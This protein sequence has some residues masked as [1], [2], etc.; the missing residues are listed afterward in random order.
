MRGAVRGL[1]VLIYYTTFD[2][3]VG[4]D[5][6]GVDGNGTSRPCSTE[7]L[8]QQGAEARVYRSNFFGKPTIIKE[9]FVKTY[10]V[11]TLDQ[12]LTNRRMTQ[13]VRSMARCRKN[14][15][16]TPAVYHMDFKRRSI[17]MEDIH[18]GISLKEYIKSLDRSI[19]SE[20]KVLRSLVENI[21]KILAKMHDCDI[22]HGDLTTSNMIY[23]PDKGHIT[24][25]D[26]GLSTVSGLVEDKGV[27]LYVLERAFLSTHPNTEDLF[28]ALLDSYFSS[29]GNAK[30]VIGK[31]DE[32]RLRGRKRTMVG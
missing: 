22:I 27:D 3:A 10:R 7:V 1:T 8:I 32:V 29:T 25:I 13:E 21:G 18:D 20:E 9:R 31:L 4:M 23:T 17:Y 26:F 16:R 28:Q 24:L 11:P 2:P 30:A 5:V 6:D 19:D 12:K 14:G 15:I